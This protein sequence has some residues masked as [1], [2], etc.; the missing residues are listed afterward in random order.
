MTKSSLLEGNTRI[1]LFTNLFQLSL[2]YISFAHIKINMLKLNIL[3]LV[4]NQELDTG[5]AQLCFF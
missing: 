1:E 2:I 3:I 5:Q 4:M